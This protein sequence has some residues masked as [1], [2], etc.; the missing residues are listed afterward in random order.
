MKPDW[1]SARLADADPV[2]HYARRVADETTLFVNASAADWVGRA[3]ADGDELDARVHHADRSALSAA[4]ATA[5]D[6]L[7]ARDEPETRRH[8]IRYRWDT[9]EGRTIAVMETFRVHRDPDGELVRVGV[10][11]DVELL[12]A[13][14][15]ALAT[16]RDRLALVLDG[17]RLGLWDWNMQ[18][19]E[20]V[21]NERW[22]EIVGY[23]LE[24]LQPTT[25]E[26]WAEFANPED[27]AQSDDLIA[28][29]AA[30]ELPYYDIECRMR[31]RDGSWVWVRDRG[32]IVEWT[33]DGKPL[34]MT[35]TH[36]DVT[37]RKHTEDRLVAEA[38]TDEL[39]GLA[40]RR[41]LERELRD[42]ADAAHAVV[43]IDLDGFKDINDQLGHAHGDDVLVAVGAAI[44]AAVRPDDLPVRLAGDEFVVLVG[45]DDPRTV[46]AVASRI[47]ETIARVPSGLPDVPQVGASI[48]VAASGAR[49]RGPFDLM[50]AADRHLY[51]A[52][53]AGGRQ[54]AGT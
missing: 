31:H 9:E 17:T 1:L 51:D 37:E 48:G 12:A 32:K 35:G 27:L 52:K 44:A 11:R 49:G 41:R 5:A 7:A 4:H 34:R 36:E 15:R 30:G 50:R 39:T 28:R 13:A 2:L 47:A 18:S 6:D 8:S 42:R 23:R 25:I 14:E 19:G 40:N 10:L 22:A 29:H 33:A 38:M 3:P 43:M 16:E 46:S 54:I 26:T 45:T 24:E 20:T 21:F 53:R